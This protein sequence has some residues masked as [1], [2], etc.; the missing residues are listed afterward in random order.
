M[1][2]S[3]WLVPYDDSPFTKTT[4]ELINDTVPRQFLAEK[5]YQAFPPHVTLTSDVD[6]G[7]KSPQE[8][9]DSLQFGED[10]KP[11]HHEVLIELDTVTAEDPK[12]RKMNISVK[13]NEN[14]KKLA[15]SC[16]QQTHSVSAEQAQAWAKDEYRPHMSLLYADVPTQDVERKIPLIEMK[17]GFAYG[18]LFACCGGSFSMGGLITVVDTSSNETKDWKRVAQR[19]T[20]WAMWR[21]TRNLI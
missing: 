19:E 9:L 14:L 16:R 13:E 18:D 20:P 8:W 10:Y 17:I 12:F 6:L 21:A 1:P 3:L 11:Q 2:Y 4:Q 7:G 15:A 5:D